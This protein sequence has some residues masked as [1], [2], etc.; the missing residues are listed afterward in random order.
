M[1]RRDT[2]IIAVLVNAGLLVVL[3][4]TAMRSGKHETSPPVQ[5]AK[6]H[7]APAETMAGNLTEG[8]TIDNLLNQYAS[9]PTLGTSEE[10]E[11]AL[12]E[13]ATTTL[14]LSLEPAIKP[15][16]I[17]QAPPPVTTSTNTP[18]VASVTVKKGDMLEKLA[19]AHGTTVA[20]IMKENNLSSSQLKIGQVLRIPTKEGSNS[21]KTEAPSGESTFYVVKEGDSPWLIASKNHVKLE[22]LL[23]LNNLDEQKARRLRPGDKLRIR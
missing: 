12:S 15:Q 16:E 6:T 3:F 4:A 1:S 7:I 9:I 8:E 10:Q 17:V 2:I 5:L 18:S 11:I 19:R 21:H 14:P 20:A 23:R 13:E 22:E